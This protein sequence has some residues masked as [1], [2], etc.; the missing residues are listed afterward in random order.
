MKEKEARLV[1]LTQ[2]HLNE[3]LPL[4]E[5]MLCQPSIQEV[6]ESSKSTWWLFLS[7]FYR[8]GMEAQKGYFPGISNVVPSIGFKG[9]INFLS[10]PPSYH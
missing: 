6:T 8:L 1:V 5:Y 3:S 9:F 7:P 2:F 10:P 4:V